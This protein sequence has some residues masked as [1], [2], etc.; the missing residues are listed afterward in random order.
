MRKI[1]FLIIL[2]MIVISTYAQNP[3]I[4]VLFIGNSLT[5]GNST[6]IDDPSTGNS[7][8]YYFRELSEAAGFNVHV[9]MYAPNG[10]YIYDD[11]NNS[12]NIGH[13]NSTITEARINSRQWDYIIV[14]DNPGS[15]MWSE[16]YLSGDVGNANVQLYNKIV[17]NNACTHEIFY[18]TQGYYDGLPSAYWNSGGLSLTSDDNI[19][20]TIRSYR[21]A[22]Y[23]NNNGMQDLVAPIGLA[24]N[25]YCNDG[26]SRDDLYYDTAHPTYKA[27]Y[28]N[29]A[30]LFSEIFKMNPENVNYTGGFSD[31]QYLRQIAYETVMDN[32]IFAEINIDTYTP[33]LSFNANE[34]TVDDTYST[35]QWYLTPNPISGAN[36]QSYTIAQ[37]G[38]YFAEVTD[39]N[40]CK[41]RSKTSN[42]DYITGIYLLND[43]KISVFPNPAQNI[44]NLTG[45]AVNS[46][47]SITDVSGQAVIS[48]IANSDT[49]TINISNLNQATY[50]VKIVNENNVT[51]KKII[52]K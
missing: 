35:Y 24:W 30:V 34:I 31:A 41:Q 14:Q 25:R 1:F 20:S 32:T 23:L 42:Y 52:K 40:G 50:F 18:A 16:G 49:H 21:N 44:I 2:G 45:L 7:M 10:K 4:S 36:T 3:E 9:E 17:A 29:A 6:N 33:E 8:A 48:E 38:L 11:P 47:I 27:S 28:L 26:H 46:I 39:A 13:C 37:T 15:Y 22:L 51:V 12:S 43:S 19:Q 5:N